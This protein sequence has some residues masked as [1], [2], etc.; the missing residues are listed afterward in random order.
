MPEAPQQYALRWREAAHRIGS[1]P[2]VSAPMVLVCSRSDEAPCPL[3]LLQGMGE[4]VTTV[5]VSAARFTNIAELWLLIAS[6]LTLP[7]PKLPTVGCEK[8]DAH[9]ARTQR[10][11]RLAHRPVSRSF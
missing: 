7:H 11:S 5:A 2:L 10:D 4:G 1:D 9:T 3:P 6:R 8:T